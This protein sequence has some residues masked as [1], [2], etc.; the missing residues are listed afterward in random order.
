MT[1]KSC[2]RQTG[3]R[4]KIHA[5]IPNVAD[6]LQPPRLPLPTISVT[7]VQ[8]SVGCARVSVCPDNSFR[9]KRPRLSNDGEVGKTSFDTAD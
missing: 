6:R 3:Q 4:E 7:Q 2:T 9:R 8:K 5:D 1:L